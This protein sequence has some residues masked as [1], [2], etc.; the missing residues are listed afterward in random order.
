MN[1]LRKDKAKASVQ[2]AEHQAQEKI[3]QNPQLQKPLAGVEIPGVQGVLDRKLDGKC[4][5]ITTQYAKEVL[6]GVSV[7]IQGQT[8]KIDVESMIKNHDHMLYD[9]LRKGDQLFHMDR[10]L[11]WLRGRTGVDDENQ[12]KAW[13]NN[14]DDWYPV[15]FSM[16]TGGMPLIDIVLGEPGNFWT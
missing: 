8:K 11:Y 4:K 3:R 5:E 10:F 7:T 14:H 2:W 9:Q 6:E 16:D 13:I 12:L 15:L 1:K